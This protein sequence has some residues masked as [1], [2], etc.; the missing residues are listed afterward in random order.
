[1][2]RDRDAAGWAD[3][4]LD[5]SDDDD[6]DAS[7]DERPSPHPSSRRAG[8][9]RWLR[10]RWMLPVLVTALA[11]LVV[12][13]VGRQFRISA[14]ADLASS[15]QLSALQVGGASV[16][17]P[18][19][20]EPTTFDAQGK[21]LVQLQVQVL[22]S[23]KQ[24]VR[25][26]VRGTSEPLLS[27]LGP[28]TSTPV[29]PG[30]TNTLVL[31]GA[32]DCTKAPAPQWSGSSTE[33]PEI[34]EPLSLDIDVALP[35]DLSSTAS[36]GDDGPVVRHRY[37]A[38]DGS[39]GWADLRQ[40]FAYA[41]DPMASGALSVTASA[42]DDG[43]M[44]LSAR[45]ETDTAM[46]LSVQST[47]WLRLSSDV[48]LPA[49]VL[50]QQDLTTVLRLNPDCRRALPPSQGGLELQVDVVTSWDEGKSQSTQS[51]GGSSTAA[52]AARQVALACR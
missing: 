24:P 21:L 25:L 31:R 2:A 7:G 40:Q 12:V 44:A 41:C 3:D 22:N 17:S 36:R 10:S 49:Q 4:V 28:A 1:M 20:G 11:L 6:G 50:P 34:A 27:L 13:S 43:T 46:T 19:T 37:L 32:V 52:W 16:M 29:I 51:P 23:G 48:Q 15:Q 26:T 33:P 18:F 39:A 30:G 9:P 47:P 14:A 42:R 45:N 5:L 8:R 35:K 38:S